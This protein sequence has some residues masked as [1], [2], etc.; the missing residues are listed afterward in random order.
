MEYAASRF[1]PIYSQKANKKEFNIKIKDDLLP[2]AVKSKDFLVKRMLSSAFSNESFNSDTK[3]LSHLGVNKT[4]IFSSKK[5]SIFTKEENNN[6]NSN[7]IANQS[8]QKRTLKNIFNRNKYTND[9]SNNIKINNIAVSPK[10]IDINST[11]SL[12]KTTDEDAGAEII[13]E[14]GFNFNI[15]NHF[16]RNDMHYLDSKT[17]KGQVDNNMDNHNL[18]VDYNFINQIDLK[19]QIN[20]NSEIKK[21]NKKYYSLDNFNFLIK[22][23]CNKNTTTRNYYN[24]FNPNAFANITNFTST[25]F[26][27]LKNKTLTADKYRHPYFPS[28]GNDTAKNKILNQS[29]Y[30]FKN[31]NLINSFKPFKYKDSSGRFAVTNKYKNPDTR[32]ISRID[33][34]YINL[35]QK[36]RNI[37]NLIQPFLSSNLKKLNKQK[38]NKPKEP[39]LELNSSSKILK[40]QEKSFLNI[41]IYNNNFNDLKLYTDIISDKPTF[42]NFNSTL[43]HQS[44]FYLPKTG[45]SIAPKTNYTTFNN[46]KVIVLD[47]NKKIKK[48]EILNLNFLHHFNQQGLDD[49]NNND[50]NNY[51]IFKKNVLNKT[52]NIN[53]NNRNN[54]FNYYNKNNKANNDTIYKHHFNCSLKNENLKNSIL[55]N[56]AETGL[57]NIPEHKKSLSE[58]A[59][60]TKKSTNRNNIQNSSL[61][62]EETITIKENQ[63]IE[64]FKE[65]NIIEPNNPTELLSINNNINNNEQIQKSFEDPEHCNDLKCDINDKNYNEPNLLN[66]SENSHSST[67]QENH[68]SL[69]KNKIEDINRFE[70][71]SIKNLSQENVSIIQKLSDADKLTDQSNESNNKP[72]SQLSPA[73][74]VQDEDKDKDNLSFDKIEEKDKNKKNPLKGFISMENSKDKLTNLANTKGVSTSTNFYPVKKLFDKENLQIKNKLFYSTN[75]EKKTNNIFPNTNRA[76]LAEKIYDINLSV[77]KKEEFKKEKMS[78]V[79]E[80]LN[81]IKYLDNIKFQYLIKNFQRFEPYI[82]KPQVIIKPVNMAK[83]I[84][85]IVIKHELKMK[86]LKKL[87]N[88]TL[89]KEIQK[90]NLK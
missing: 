60:I 52:Y 48:K 71:N 56:K 47:K 15:K 72:N 88:S 44:S 51:S 45:N 69:N 38:I 28:Y 53:K 90:K 7:I 50:N 81:E 40:R 62:A 41:N 79:N 66:K 8:L 34:L 5:N 31:F 30:P 12:S 55:N 4:K 10:N 2:K 75:Y 64:I 49:I 19:N 54:I 83:N 27:E 20:K 11:I 14:N 68:E 80:E 29:D 73:A 3:E 89:K 39:I 24:N 37:E 63:T 74:N 85:N 43:L 18:F 82:E 23:P 87:N 42:N 86:I 36:E 58:I 22:N 57:I 67:K 70:N 16:K 26:F 59:L 35:K 17:L 78:Y 1:N 76:N 33:K 61:L 25:N 46:K 84:E 77:M 9:H 21:F 65:H 32:V 6:L 13:A